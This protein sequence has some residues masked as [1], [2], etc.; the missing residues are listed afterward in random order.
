M[1]HGFKL[2]RRV[3]RLRAPLLLAAFVLAFAGCDNPDAF[4][5]DRGAPTDAETLM[6]DGTGDESGVGVVPV[7]DPAMAA[8]TRRGIPIGHFAQPISTFGRLYNGGHQ[9]FSPNSIVRELSAIRA[10]GG[11]VMIPFAG[12]PKYYKENGHFSLSKWK[13]RVNR[14]RGINLSSFVRD[15]TIIGHYM[16]DEPNDP[17]NWR[18]RRVSPSVLEEMAKYSKRLW[19]GIPTV[20]R[21]EPSYLGRN[22]RYLDAAWA[23]YLS[24][25]GSPESFIRRNAADAQHRGVRLVVGLNVLKGGTP[26][27]TKMTPR[28]VKS[29]G[30]TLL[31][32]SYPC[33]FISW[34]YN[35]RFLS[36]RG[37]S[38]AMGA[39]RRKAEG[40]SNRS[41]RS[42]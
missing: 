4:E 39:L 16:I 31:N 19:P 10:R 26:N 9:N 13:A 12:S 17:A 1:T 35:S 34:T 14:F 42:S 5:P 28:Q 22:H 18:G 27:G 7:S 30:S 3:A 29:W 6:A 25:K 21:T 20:V 38:D 24:R 11:R 8:A 37:M 2:P 36:S 40:R 32:G 41:C 23:Q 33:A 15:G